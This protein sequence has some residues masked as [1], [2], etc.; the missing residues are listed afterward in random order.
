MQLQVPALGEAATSGT[1][2]SSSRSTKA[3]L[4]T[5]R[6]AIMRYQGI[7]MTAVLFSE[8]DRVK[9]LRAPLPADVEALQK[10]LLF[11]P[12]SH[13][14]VVKLTAACRY[15]HAKHSRMLEK[16]Q[17]ERRQQRQQ[18]R[19]DCRRAL[20]S[21]ISNGGGQGS[22]SSSSNGRHGPNRAS[23]A[24]AADVCGAKES[25]CAMLLPPDHELMAAVLG[26]NAVATFCRAIDAGGSGMRGLMLE[27]IAC[28][29]ILAGAN[30]KQGV[31][32]G[33]STAAA[34]CASSQQ[35]VI[36]S[37]P[38]SGAGASSGG[39]SSSSSR[40]CGSGGSSSARSSGRGGS[41]S[42]NS[43]GGA[44]NTTSSSSSSGSGSGGW[45]SAMLRSAPCMQLL[46]ELLALLVAE[47]DG[48]LQLVA[49]CVTL[50][51]SVMDGAPKAE[52]EV[53]LSARGGLLVQVFGLVVQA[54]KETQQQQEQGVQQEGRDVGSLEGVTSN[55]LRCMLTSLEGASRE[56]DVSCESGSFCWD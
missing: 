6:N 37:A 27:M 50:L 42:M 13:V 56:A 21:S 41:S 20:R 29:D 43:S 49:K 38:R 3:S 15:L 33:I 45:N 24:A 30:E 1:S 17:Q 12:A 28:F 11:G 40:G 7:V 25:A 26:E 48:E 46:L 9:G 22:S 2:S 52:K 36:R 10:Q 55:V 8:C 5:L 31:Y 32:D 51:D 53:F 4:E 14:A 35:Q 23:A 19:S 44:S 16:K 39:G 34:A 54:A 18:Q 47:A